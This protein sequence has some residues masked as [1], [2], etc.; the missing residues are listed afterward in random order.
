MHNTNR[1]QS[2]GVSNSISNFNNDFMFTAAS[3]ANQLTNISKIN[4]IQDDEPD[5]LSNISGENHF[6]SFILIFFN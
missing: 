5:V 3:G 1:F 4:R 6:S 2:T